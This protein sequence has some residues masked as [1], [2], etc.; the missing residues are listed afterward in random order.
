M[1]PKS[2]LLLCAALVAGLLLAQRPCWAEHDLEFVA[3]H[4]P[5]VAMD[6]RFAT[7][8]VWGGMSDAS[9]W[10]GTAQGAYA[11]TQVGTLS[12][13]G[14]MFSL[15]GERNLRGGW[16]VGAFAF[17]DYLTFTGHREFRPLQ[18][19][20]AP[21]TPIER[22]ADAL[23]TN[24]DGNARDFG[25]G[26]YVS[27]DA[28]S[29]L[30]GVHR[31]LGGVM[32]QRVELSNYAFDYEILSGP[33]AGVTGRIDFDADYTHI[34]PFVGF[35]LPRDFGSWTLTLHG[36]LAY[37][38]PTRGVAGHVT[39]PGFDLSG[40]TASAGNG[41]HFG[42]P[43]ITLGLNVTY[44]PARLTIDLGTLLSQALVEPLVHSGIDRNLLL[45]VCWTW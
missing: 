3:E 20:F 1:T 35:A 43:S 13:D 8:P 34:T 44:R 41:K 4:L 10:S 16:H 5:E 38:L 30:L 45:S 37:P 28:E 6:N 17:Y 22:P 11:T 42:D 25:G 40:D 21:Q 14:P 2:K 36:L 12:L 32:W 29:R 26:L 18:T 27:R 31:W 24:L 33:Q 23:F 15:A 9:L 7:L 19:L 39:G